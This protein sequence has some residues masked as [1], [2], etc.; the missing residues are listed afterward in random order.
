[1]GN[2]YKLPPGPSCLI[3]CLHSLQLKGEN[4]GKKVYV[5]IY[6]YSLGAMTQRLA[7]PHDD[8]NWNVMMVHDDSDYG[9]DDDDDDADCKN[10]WKGPEGIT[11]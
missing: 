4:R 7:L 9:I 5:L 3:H 2:L 10:T 8:D 1:M 6:S 11:V